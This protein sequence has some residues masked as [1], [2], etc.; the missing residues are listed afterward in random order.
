MVAT[1][2]VVTDPFGGGDPSIPT[3]VGTTLRIAPIDPFSTPVDGAYRDELVTVTAGRGD[4]RTPADLVVRTPHFEVS[5]QGRR[6]LVRHRIPVDRIDDA[7]TTTINDELFG[8]GWLTGSETFERIFTGV[9]LTS[10]PTA[11]QAWLTFYRNSLRRYLAVPAVERRDALDDFAE[12]HRHAEDLV[13]A[14]ASV[15]ELGCCFGFLSLRLARSPERTVIASDLS[16]GTVALLDAVAGRL[17]LPLQTMVADA[18]RIPRADRSVD[19][20]LLI[21]LLEHLDPAHCRRAIDEALRVAD[22]R[23]IIAVPYEDEPTP[24]FGHLWTLGEADLRAWAAA[25]DGWTWSVHEHLGGWLV[26]DRP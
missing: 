14:D 21:H 18:A 12:I 5:R 23:V 20:V 25:T 9:V 19:A 4:G 1:D 7:L 26:F 11:M 24:A 16:A 2:S 13:P 22:R 6:L 15:L 3:T 10:Q 17:G 8:P